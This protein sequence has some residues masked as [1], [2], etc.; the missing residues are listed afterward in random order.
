MLGKRLLQGVLAITLGTTMIV[1]GQ[2]PAQAQAYGPYYLISED[3]NGG[4]CLDDPNSNRNDNIRI[5]IWDCLN[6]T[7]QR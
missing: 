6:G 5:V 7:N 3:N 4:H 1:L 2:A